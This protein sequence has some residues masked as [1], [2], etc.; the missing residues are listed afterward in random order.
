MRDDKNIQ[1][2]LEIIAKIQKYCEGKRYEDFIADE[3]LTEACVFNLAQLGETSHKISDELVRLHP[4]IVWNGLYGLRNR[5]VH[6]Y[7]GTNPKLVWEIISEDLDE[8]KEQ[9]EDINY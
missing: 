7:Q 1:K 4:E 3:I 8:L 2:M 5:L 6:D 9:L